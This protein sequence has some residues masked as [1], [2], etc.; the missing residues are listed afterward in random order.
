MNRNLI[1]LAAMLS[2]APW[3]GPAHA[4][5]PIF[6]AYTGSQVGVTERDTNLGQTSF[7]DTEL[8]AAGIA[9]TTA[10][11]IYLT[12]GSTITEYAL[13]G[14]QVNQLDFGGGIVYGGVT[15][16]GNQLFATYTGSQ[17]GVTL[18]SLELLQSNSFDTGVD[19]TDLAVGSEDIIYLTAGNAIYAYDFFGN[20]TDEMIFSDAGILY[21]GIDYANNLLFASYGGSQQGVTVR[22][23]LLDQLYFFETPFTA[24]GIAVGNNSNLFLTSAN[25]IYEY[26]VAGALLN[27]MTFP[28]DGIL[29]TAIDVQAIPEPATWALLITGFGLV[30]FA[31]RRRRSQ[32]FA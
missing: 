1:I 26:S 21:T 20:L 5:G 23:L 24:T 30:G 6:A 8:T 31:A 19:A 25:S 29:Y 22:D 13:D 32:A 27:T 15:T 16:R 12:S 7:F 11:R 17:Q 14:T 9:V 4:A 10:D 3:T 2:G 28:D 18:R